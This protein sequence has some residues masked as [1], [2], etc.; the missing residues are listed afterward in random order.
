MQNIILI[1]VKILFNIV[2]FQFGKYDIY[3]YRLSQLRFWK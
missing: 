1:K 3:V 2:K